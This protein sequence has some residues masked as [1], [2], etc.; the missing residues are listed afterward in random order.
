[1]L[2]VLGGVNSNTFRN[3]RMRMAG[4]F[5]ALQLNAEKIIILVEMMLMGQSD[6]PCFQGGRQLVRDLK[7]RLFPNGQRFNSDQEY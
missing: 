4:G 5:K 1:M 2:D 6:L 7:E 3:F